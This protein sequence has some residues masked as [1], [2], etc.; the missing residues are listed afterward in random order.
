MTGRIITIIV[1]IGLSGFLSA[2]EAALLS[3]ERLRMRRIIHRGGRAGRLL[4][5]WKDHPNEMIST[6]LILNNLVNILASV[7]ASAIAVELFPS[8]GIAIATG[9]MTFLIITFGE[10]T[11]KIYARANGERLAFVALTALIPCSKFLTPVVKFFT[12]LGVGLSRLIGG[13]VVSRQNLLISDSDLRALFDESAEEGV[14]AQDEKKMLGRVLTFSDTIVREVMVP[15]P[16][17]ECI[18]IDEDRDHFVQKVLGTGHSRFP[19]YRESFDNVIGT[20]YVKDI[21]GALVKGG[22]VNIEML[23]R[24][25]Y[26]IP[27]TKKLSE[28][29]REF[30]SGRQHMAIV[31]DEHG[32]TV[33]LVTLEDLLEEITGEIWDEYDLAEKTIER[34]QDGS[35][36]VSAKEDIYKINEVLNLDMPAGEFDTLGGL[37]LDFLGRLPKKGEEFTYRGLKFRIEDT[38]RSRIIKIRLKKL[39]T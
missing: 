38:N 32:V 17:M 16:D 24:E 23:L 1:M 15:R 28:L 19:V 29:L 4:I 6:I 34:Q 2:S 21:L 11:P 26:L 3:L 8:N 27:E 12:L 18:N 20:I 13:R 25:P 9:V 35:Y 39:D 37:T 31:I 22:E 7:L 5:F 10:V 30:R 33:G 14:L 36:L